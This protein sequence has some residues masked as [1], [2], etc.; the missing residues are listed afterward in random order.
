MIDITT[1]SVGF[2]FADE[3]ELTIHRP[4][5]GVTSTNLLANVGMH[6]PRLPAKHRATIEQANQRKENTP[7]VLP[8]SPLSV[9]HTRGRRHRELGHLKIEESDEY[10][11]PSK[12][13]KDTLRYVTIPGR[14]N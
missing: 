7:R 9:R 6:R 2:L 14:E 1:P 8:T 5:S 11:K 3:P 13:S 12:A 10:D 4:V